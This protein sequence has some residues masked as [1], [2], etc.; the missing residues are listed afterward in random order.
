MAKILLAERDPVVIEAASAALRE[1]HHAVVGAEDGETAWSEL[2]RDRFDLLLLSLEL[3]SMRAAELLRRVRGARSL[4]SLPVI[5]RSE[6]A[7]EVNRVLAFELGADDFVGS[8]VSF[9]ELALRVRAVLRRS[10]RRLRRR[11]E[12]PFSIGGLEFRPKSRELLVGSSKQRLTPV[13]NR[14]L[15]VLLEQ[16]DRV[17]RREELLHRVWAQLEVGRRTVDSQVRRL[18]NKMGGAAHLLETVRGV[19][20]RLRLDQSSAQSPPE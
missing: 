5:V 14:L 7:D 9:R 17:W 1:H 11:R 10:S 6:H 15:V 3:H 18:R 20:Y 12:D 4:T 13:E 8:E 16:P 19:G 2:G